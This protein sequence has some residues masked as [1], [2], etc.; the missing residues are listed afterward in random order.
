[1]IGI[2]G[3]PT[4]KEAFALLAQR[5]PYIKL[6]LYGRPDPDNPGSWREE[7]LRQ[8]DAESGNVSYKGH[9]DDMAAIWTGAHAAVQASYGGEGVPKSL[10]EAAACGRAVVASD[11]PGC[12]EI[13]EDGN[14]G[15]LVP[16]YD[17]AALAAAIEK[18]AGDMALCRRMGENSRK[19]VAGDM[20]A[21]RVTAQTVDLY[22]ACLSTPE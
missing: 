20:S 9:A 19:M 4:L 15:F 13:V 22:R 17:A 5:A 11:V 3:L 10:L 16:P 7:T 2:K 8:W 1:M 21:E 6:H 14:N 12:R 18:L